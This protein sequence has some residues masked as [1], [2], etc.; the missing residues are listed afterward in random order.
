MF[1]NFARM[2]MSR[3]IV[4]METGVGI[5]TGQGQNPQIMGKFS[6]DGGKTFSNEL[7]QPVGTE[8]SYWTEIFWTQIGQGRSFIAKINYS[9]PTK[10]VIAGCFVEIETEN[11]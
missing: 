8:G 4:C 1:K 3:F 11:D 10:F 2:T 6:I 7:W 5:A 9:E